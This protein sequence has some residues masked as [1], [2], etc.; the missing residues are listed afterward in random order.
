MEKQTKILPAARHEKIVA[1]LEEEWF[2][3]IQDLQS[4]LHVSH[5]TAHRDLDILAGKQL[6]RKVRGGV[7]R[8]VEIENPQ[9][10][11]NNCAMCSSRVSTRT[12]VV[13]FKRDGGRSYACCPHCGI[14]MLMDR[15]DIESALARD[16]IYGRMVNILQA[17]YIV[18]SLVRLC[19]VPTTLCFASIEDAK[20]FQKGFNGQLLSFIEARQHLS[21]THQHH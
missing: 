4:R 12:E 21:E 11:L 8:A 1:W 14:M 6:V 20:R 7:M 15:T 19:C 13:I 16:F 17:T 2:L 10:S 5:M 18:G 3:S 9:V